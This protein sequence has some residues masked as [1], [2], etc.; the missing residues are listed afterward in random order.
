MSSLPFA[1]ASPGL[2]VPA[3]KPIFRKREQLVG[4]AILIFA[5]LLILNWFSRTIGG[6]YYYIA[7]YLQAAFG[8]DALEDACASVLLVKD[9]KTVLVDRDWYKL[10]RCLGNRDGFD[11]Q[12][13]VWLAVCVLGRFQGKC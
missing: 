11:R 9:P 10:Q 5:T 12:G 13:E 1:P 6:T 3:P 2:P 7:E 8:D 4:T